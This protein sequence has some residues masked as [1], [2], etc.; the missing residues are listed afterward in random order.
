M[1]ELRW[2]F[3]AGE[4]KG[5]NAYRVVQRNLPAAA[6]LLLLAAVLAYAWQRRP[7]LV[8]PRDP[9]VLL[10]GGLL[11]AAAWTLTSRRHAV[12]DRETRTFRLEVR[13]LLVFRQAVE[14]RLEDVLWVRFRDPATASAADPESAFEPGVSVG[15]RDGEV[16]IAAAGIGGGEDDALELANWLRRP[17]LRDGASVPAAAPGEPLRPTGT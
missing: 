13:R 11:Y 4:V 16:T 14:G 9:G 1:L 8:S 6:S 7:D 17:Y 15:H 10:L 3:R 5:R 12:F 2:G